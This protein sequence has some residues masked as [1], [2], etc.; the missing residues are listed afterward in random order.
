MLFFLSTILLLLLLLYYYYNKLFFLFFFFVLILILL[1]ADSAI[2]PVSD[3]GDGTVRFA[4][5][6]A[7]I[8]EP[9]LCS[10]RRVMPGEGTDGEDKQ[11]CTQDMSLLLWS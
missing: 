3:C 4:A 6:R 11:L 9:S 10:H 5:E 2:L 1:L 8:S 7:G